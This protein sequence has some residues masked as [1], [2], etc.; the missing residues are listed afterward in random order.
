MFVVAMHVASIQS[1]HCEN[2]WTSGNL[3]YTL[4]LL[5]VYIVI[6]SFLD[7]CNPY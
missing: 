2:D 3:N 5:T 7:C 4:Q 6:N 1:L